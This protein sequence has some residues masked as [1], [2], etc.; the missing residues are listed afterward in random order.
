VYIFDLF[1]LA[2]SGGVWV[3]FGNGD[4][5]FPAL[6]GPECGISCTVSLDYTQDTMLGKMER[7]LYRERESE[8]ILVKLRTHFLRFSRERAMY[9]K[10]FADCVNYIYS[11]D[12]KK[13]ST[14][15]NSF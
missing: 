14:D 4:R 9:S 10:Q 11:L 12:K 6:L 1:W 8:Y 3:G 5:H 15:F 2:F 13:F 7:L